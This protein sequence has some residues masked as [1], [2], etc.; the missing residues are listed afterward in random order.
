MRGSIFKGFESVCVCLC[1]C[2]C[3]CVCDLKVNLIDR[4][5][6][7]YFCKFHQTYSEFIFF[8]QNKNIWHRILV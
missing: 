2:V 1:V 5:C 3:V 8:N 6:G 7:K 4:I